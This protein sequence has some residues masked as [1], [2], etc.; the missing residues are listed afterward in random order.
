[1]GKILKILCI[2]ALWTFVGYII[3]AID[4]ES[5]R[6]VGMEGAY[7]PFFV[8]LV[9]ALWYT[10]SLI[11]ASSI[12]SLVITTLLILALA[13][14]MMGIMNIFLGFVIVSIIVFILYVQKQH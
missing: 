1:M 5:V 7:L 6:D 12:V 8:P 14:T 13:L 9:I 10:L 2:L 11:V 3:V 4:P